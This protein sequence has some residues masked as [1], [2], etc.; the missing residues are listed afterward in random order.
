LTQFAAGPYST[1]LLADAGARVIKIEPPAGEPYRHEGISLGQAPD[2]SAVGSYI[3]RFSRDKQSV[4][5]D[6]KTPGGV[7]ALR[8]L[9]KSADV[10]VQNFKHGT[11]ERLGIGYPTL[12][13]VNPRL[14]YAS[15]TGFGQPDFLPSPYGGAPAFAVVSEAMGGVMDRLG[16]ETCAPHWSGV[17]LGDLFPASLAVAGILMALIQRE[18]TGVGQLVDIALADAMTSLNEKAISTYTVTGAAPPRGVDDDESFIVVRAAGGWVLVVMDGDADVTQ[19]CD[20]VGSPHLADGLPPLG[21]TGRHRF[22]TDV[23]GHT[24][25]AWVG[26]RDVEAVC[27]LLRD[28]CAFVTKVFTARDV[29]ASEH[30]RAR[31]MLI[32]VDYGPYGV[33]TV[34]NSPIKFSADPPR[35]RPRV[36]LT[37][38]DTDAVLEELALDEAD[39]RRADA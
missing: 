2:G 20:L 23:V 4:A 29:T 21:S 13:E 33:H 34:V 30:T 25:Q 38:E 24:V 22:I 5:L 16:D 35:L 1:M 32:E 8:A 17:S 26:Q 10:L 14:I 28:H 27:N 12:H 6:L 19:I 18:R 15:V 36:H 7:A 3:V 31:E 9:V 11:A 37:G 39:A